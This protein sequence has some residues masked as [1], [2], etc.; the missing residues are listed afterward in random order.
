[1]RAEGG[2][3]RVRSAFRATARESGM[4]FWTDLNLTIFHAINGLCGWSPSLDQFVGNL[5]VFGLKGLALMGTFGALWFQ[6]GADQARKREI[7][8]AMLV[9]M[10][11]SI[12]V[13][14]AISFLAPF[15]QR[16]MF[17]PDIGYRAPLF[18]FHYT[19]EDWSSFPSDQAGMMF[20]LA[21]GCWFA[22]RL[23]GALF[24]VF[25]VI[26]MLARVYVGG[27]YPGDV[28]IGAMVGVI[29]TIALTV[30][31]A[32]AFIAPPFLAVERRA[33]SLFYGLLFAGLFETGIMFGTVRTLG[34]AA[35]QL[36]TGTH[37]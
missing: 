14:R 2:W 12:F 1:V 11:L 25:S 17:T 24:G 35:L 26:A 7:L 32:R 20:S 29:V 3:A 13:I 16:P 6:T 4:G 9:A 5:D 22:S 31:P 28:F 23:W 37:A 15:E 18:K 8:I 34:K 21:T 30:R 10:S 27:H 36:L 33:P 19:I